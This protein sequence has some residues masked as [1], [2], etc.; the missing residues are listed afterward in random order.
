MSFGA[1][2]KQLREQ[3]GMTQLQLAEVIGVSRSTI[4]MYESDF[5][6]PD[7][8]TLETIAD[9]FN[10]TLDFLHGKKSCSGNVQADG[11]I[12]TNTI[13]IA[14]RDGSFTERKLTDDQIELIRRMIDQMPDFKD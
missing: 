11:I 6:E 5:R 2:L 9:Y 8:E 12:P 7:F 13:R 10:V 14:G 1:I 4:G 3:N